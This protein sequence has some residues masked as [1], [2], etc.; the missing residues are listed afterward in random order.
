MGY[1]I[2]T[3]NGTLLEPKNKVDQLIKGGAVVIETPTEFK[4]NLVCVVDNVFFDA[5]AFAYNEEEM[6]VFLS[7]DPRPKT[8]LI[9]PNADLLSGYNKQ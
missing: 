7:P 2:N 4:E 9:V 8:W 1:Y 5:A 6:K 3:I